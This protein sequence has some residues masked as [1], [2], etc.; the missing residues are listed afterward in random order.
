MRCPAGN[1]TWV[2]KIHSNGSAWRRAVGA[3]RGGAG[4]ADAVSRWAEGA[5]GCS[6]RTRAAYDACICGVAALRA[7]RRRWAEGGVTAVGGRGDASIGSARAG[8]MQLGEAR[9][10]ARRA[11]FGARAGGGGEAVGRGLAVTERGRSV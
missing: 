4:I 6:L 11:A 7:R 5:W 3:A 8:S 2:T 1:R 10:V 9:R